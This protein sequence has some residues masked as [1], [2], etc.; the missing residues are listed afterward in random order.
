MPV[1]KQGRRTV[2][3]PV[4]I[5]CLPTLWLGSGQVRL[6]FPASMRYMEATAALMAITTCRPRCILATLPSPPLLRDRAPSTWPPRPP[7]P[8][9]SRP[10]RA[11]GSGGLRSGPSL[12]LG[13]WPGS[14]STRHSRSTGSSRCSRTMASA[15]GAGFPGLAAAA[16]RVADERS[17]K[18]R[19]KRP[20]TK[21]STTIPAISGLSH[22]SRWPNA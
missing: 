11:L 18:T 14:I 17:G 22:G 3:D 19:R 7:R 10:P 20:S 1:D 5:L 16:S 21:C 6:E 8:R 13:S 12:D 9:L 4:S 15:Q 2:S